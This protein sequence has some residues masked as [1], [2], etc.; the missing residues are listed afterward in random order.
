[1]RRTAILFVMMAW[2]AAASAQVC[3]GQAP[4]GRPS[5][6]VFGA[7]VTFADGIASYGFTFGGG[8]D[9]GFGRGGFAVNHYDEDGFD[10]W[11]VG[12]VGG[13]QIAADARQRV[14]ICPVGQFSYEWRNDIQD[15]GVDVS[16]LTTGA[17]VFAGFVVA[18]SATA[19]L[20]PTVGLAVNRTRV[21]VSV[22]GFGDDRVSR[23]Y[24]VAQLGLGIVLN[25]RTAITPSVL[26]PF[27]VDEV[28]PSF[29]LVFTY[30]FGR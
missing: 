30:S 23:T 2:P 3:M 15:S 7:G 17:G 19:Q 24:G 4:I 29:S 22:E 18:E 12:A 16:A 20:V 1:M 8:T 21:E 26:I 25:R 27:G 6:M 10:T 9:A 14:Q 11:A 13:S 5:P 28:E